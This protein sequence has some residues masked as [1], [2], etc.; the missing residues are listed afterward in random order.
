MT[1]NWPNWAGC[2]LITVNKM[3]WNIFIYRFNKLDVK[4]LDEI[5]VWQIL[6]FSTA[7]LRTHIQEFS[8][9]IIEK[10]EE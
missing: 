5:I 3:G 10:I 2:P 6:I 8:L 1:I 4:L 9:Q 7:T